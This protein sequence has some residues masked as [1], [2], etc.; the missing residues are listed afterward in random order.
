MRPRKSV[1]KIMFIILSSDCL[2]SECVYEYDRM[3]NEV[4]S[5]FNFLLN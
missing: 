2:S 5:M 1:K 3:K 4:V